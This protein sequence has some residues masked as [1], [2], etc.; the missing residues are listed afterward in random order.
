MC[1]SVTMK[2]KRWS[3]L[4]LL[5]IAVALVVLI[6]SLPYNG[7][8]SA[9]SPR[10]VRLSRR[11]SL[12]REILIDV[13]PDRDVLVTLADSFYY[14]A[15]ILP[16]WLEGVLR[17]NV[18][19]YLV[20]C[21]DRDLHQTLQRQGIHAFYSARRLS[22]QNG[23]GASH[24]I[25]ALKYEVL[26]EM[27][28]LG[29]NVLLSDADVVTLQDPFVGH[30]YRDADLEAMSDGS[31]PAEAYGSVVFYDD[32]SMGWSRYAQGIQH[33]N[34]NSGLFYVQANAR[35]QSLMKRM[36]ERMAKQKYWDQQAFN[37][38]VFFLTHGEYK[39]PGISVRVMDIYT[40]M[41]SKTLFKRVRYDLVL[42]QKR[43]VMVHINYHP[44]KKAR[45]KAVSEFYNGDSG[46]LVVFPDGSE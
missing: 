7:A 12:M 26:L 24:E 46:A 27:L 1:D 6:H 8:Q 29:W 42:P 30:L 9:N 15:G 28:S 41:N 13:A 10:S 4:T 19:N 38:E 11:A 23:T 14:N 22:A 16:L 39:S 3:I 32:P 44:D 31:T 21:L 20:V 25:S 33:Y 2:S 37:E 40:Y 36:A 35:T 18:S 43:P 5:A 17:S 34:L 45:M